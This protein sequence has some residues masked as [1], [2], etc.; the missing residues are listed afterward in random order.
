MIPD[1][2]SA[3]RKLAHSRRDRYPQPELLKLALMGLC[4]PAEVAG[5]RRLYEMTRTQVAEK[6]RL[7]GA[8][9]ARAVVRLNIKTDL[10]NSYSIG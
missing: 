10:Q 5:V 2:S 3:I 1:G 8:S 7:G 9:I 6:T 4:P